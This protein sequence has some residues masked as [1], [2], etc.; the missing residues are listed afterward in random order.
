MLFV[1][2]PPIQLKKIDRNTGQVLDEVPIPEV[3]TPP[4]LERIMIANWKGTLYLFTGTETPDT[5]SVYSMDSSKP[6]ADP[7][8]PYSVMAVTTSTCSL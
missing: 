8:L 2:P 6:V 7:I 3:L 4:P 5:T 1:D